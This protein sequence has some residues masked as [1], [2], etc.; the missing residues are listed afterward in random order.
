VSKSFGSQEDA[1]LRLVALRTI[2]KHTGL[3]L[4][5][6]GHPRFYGIRGAS[7]RRVVGASAFDD[8]LVSPQ[9]IELCTKVP[10]PALEHSGHT[11]TVLSRQ[12]RPFGASSGT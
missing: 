5:D 2:A 1:E 11:W 8:S 10:G 4:Q 12:H 7:S 9:R 3:I 6:H